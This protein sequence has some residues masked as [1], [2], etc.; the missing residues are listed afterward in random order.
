MAAL[1]ID[2]CFVSFNMSARPAMM[3]TICLVL[4]AITT[5]KRLI[6]SYKDNEMERFYIGN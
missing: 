4:A 2:L 3:L 5:Q 1:A 6:S